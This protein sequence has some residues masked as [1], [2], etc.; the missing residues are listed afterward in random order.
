MAQ[1]DEVVNGLL[2]SH[3]STFSTHLTCSFVPSEDYFITVN[4]MVVFVVMHTEQR[5]N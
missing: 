3:S 1:V 2:V 5:T 4:C